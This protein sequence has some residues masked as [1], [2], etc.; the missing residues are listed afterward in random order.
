V[1]GHR[2]DSLAAL[3][4]EALE[5]PSGERPDW[6]RRA[7]HGDPALA[8][9]V[10]DA[11]PTDSGEAQTPSPLIKP[12]EAIPESARRIG[13]YALRG[14]LGEGTFGVVYLADQQ[15]PIPR[16]VAIK[17]LKL[18]DGNGGSDGGGDAV[19]ERFERERRMLARLDHPSIAH[20]L[21]AGVTN[22]GRPWFALEYVHGRPL[23]HYCDDA[24]LTIDARLRLFEEICRAVQ[25]AHQNGVL[26]RD[27]KPGNV[28]VSSGAPGDGTPAWGRPTVIDFGIAEALGGEEPT[29]SA[30][31]GGSQSDL[32]GRLVGT[33]E[34]MAPEQA[35]GLEVDA[36]CDIY[37]LGAVLHQL[38][39]GE[40]PLGV[41]GDLE[42]FL[43]RLRDVDAPL[44]SVVVAALPD[45]R[46]AELARQRGTTSKKL[47]RALRGDLD[48]IVHKCLAK[49]R[50]QRYD[51]AADLASDL[52]RHFESR[53]I[54]AAPRSV[55]YR[56]RCFVRRHRTAVTAV[57]ISVL[58]LLLAIVSISASLRTTLRARDTE[59]DARLHV[60]R[61][62]TDAN[63]ALSALISLI[64]QISLDR[65]AS[66]VASTP[67][68][69]LAAAREQ[70]IEPFRT[71]P[72]AQAQVRVAL[73]KALL[74]LD[75]PRAAER[76]IAAAVALLGTLSPSADSALIE[77]LRTQAAIDEHRQRYDQAATTLDRAFDLQ[78]ASDP[79]DA[80]GLNVLWIDRARLAITRGDGL[81]ARRAIVEARRELERI[82]DALARRRAES[83]ASFFEAEALVLDGQ[84][85]EALSAIA[86]N[87]AF[88]RANMPDHWWVAE[89]SAVEAAALIGL[90]QIERGRAILAE[91]EPKLLRALPPGSSPRRVI[92]T[93]V[94]KAFASQGLETDAAHWRTL[95]AP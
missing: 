51:S 88:N 82:P 56:T 54:E 50:S 20:V 73:A 87:L 79:E 86:P 74:S 90:G 25:H 30:A 35:L 3:V 71:R 18:R 37:G 92:G 46:A 8:A 68:E 57:V 63:D 17:V 80:V 95:G 4:R 14:I 40:P 53:P 15:L 47:V 27:L 41:A 89:I 2:A 9:R 26:H 69:I 5:V 55:R 13:P 78:H 60:E 49:D 83:S 66:G 84:W 43:R 11:L 62:A 36:R 65:S 75:H 52:R 64:T 42:S 23:L 38:L 24:R 7:C 91:A 59:R 22:D 85:K 31:N 19:V 32:P 1:A 61:A 33:L 16:R 10:R 81:A 29:Q 12:L 48:W 45:D 77:A 72:H 21:D 39:T 34:Y 76:E 67:D 44:P 58:S 94:A 93:L 28:L 70:L 6:L